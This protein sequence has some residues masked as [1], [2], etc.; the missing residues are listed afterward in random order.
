MKTKKSAFTL[1]ELLIVVAIIAILAAIAVP[2]FL[3]AQIRSKV[4]RVKSDMRSFATAIEA[5]RVDYNQPPPSAGEIPGTADVMV[6]APLTLGGMTGQTGIMG[7]W[8]TTPIAYF[9]NFQVRDAFVPDGRRPDTQLFS[10]HTY[11]FRWPKKKPAPV[12]DTT[13]EA[14]NE[15]LN[16]AQFKQIYGDW[17][18]FSIGPENRYNNVVNGPINA[19]TGNVGLP[20]DPTN[21]TV[22]AGNIFR[23]QKGAEQRSWFFSGVT[24]GG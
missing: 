24:Y 8:I 6:G 5:Y 2:N 10:Y 18:M 3:E 19:F 9:T 1:I 13:A 22:S 23:S 17:R 12:S 15:G 20:Y 11:P 14:F 21:G 7:W 4:S 16:G